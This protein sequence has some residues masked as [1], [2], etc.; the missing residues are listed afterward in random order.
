MQLYFL[1][2]GCISAEL[3]GG[4]NSTVNNDRNIF[5]LC[6]VKN[7][8]GL[9][10]ICLIVKKP[11]R[12]RKVHGREAVPVAHSNSSTPCEGEPLT[13]VV[14]LKVEVFACVHVRVCVCMHMCARACVCV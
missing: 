6:S 7:K 10:N 14:R 9:K 12:V 3:I 5:F 8:S 4:R 13:P 2:F 1:F 11:T